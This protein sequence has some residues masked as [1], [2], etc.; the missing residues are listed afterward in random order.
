MTEWAYFMNS[1]AAPPPSTG[2]TAGWSIAAVERD[3]GIGKDTLRVWERRYGFPKPVR[4]PQGERLYP[5]DQVERLRHI[6]RLLDA[7]HRPGRIVA[8]ALDELLRLGEG[9]IGGNGAAAPTAQAPAG[10]IGA[11]ATTS[12][13]VAALLDQL[14]RDDAPGLRSA[15]GQALLRLGLGRFVT[16]LAVPLLTEVGAAWAR[17]QLEIYQEHLCSEL[18]ESTL[19][20]AQL[21]APASD[22]NASPR[23]LL[24]T[25]PGEQHGL[26]LL[27]ADALFAVEGCQRLNL[28]RQT[29]QPDLLLAAQRQGAQV[30]ALSFSAAQPPGSIADSLTD[31]RRHLDPAVELWAGVPFPTLLRRDIGGVQLL[32]RLDDIPAAVRRWRARQ[33]PPS[34]AAPRTDT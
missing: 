18:L 7:G 25:L 21:T 26:G 14:R 23:V 6:R 19:R 2:S 17:G 30:V 1:F 13:S 8:L 32:G 15:L 22:P 33:A 3:T 4:D 34:D 11:A 27:M 29:P 10:P 28:G 16:E 24:S 12:E 5:P 20:A 9:P 31:L